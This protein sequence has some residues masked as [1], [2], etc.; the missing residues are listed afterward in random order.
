MTF[1]SPSASLDLKV[2]IFDENGRPKRIEM[3]AFSKRKRI[4]VDRALVNVSTL[5]FVCE[6]L[7]W[8]IAEKFMLCTY[9]SWR[10]DQREYESKP[11][12]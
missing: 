6:Y 11:S 12:Y 10:Q 4:G 5:T 2:P 1:S 3:Y 8:H 7:S 9:S